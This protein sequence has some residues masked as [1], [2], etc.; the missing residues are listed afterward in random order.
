MKDQKQKKP[1]NKFA[2]FSG[3]GFQMF[4]IIGLGTFIGFKLDEK[5]PNPKNLFTLGFS[6]SAV[7]ISIV[8]VIRQI[9]SATK[10]N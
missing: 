4:A 2:R 3:I 7:I 9:T 8:Y 6:L 1:L 10:D 5:Y